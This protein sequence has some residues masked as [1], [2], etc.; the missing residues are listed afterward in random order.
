MAKNILIIEDIEPVKKVIERII[1]KY[2]LKTMWVTD[3]I[4][5]KEILKK[6]RF[7]IFLIDLHLD[8]KDGISLGAGIKK[9]FPNSYFIAMTG[10]DSKETFKKCRQAGFD[11][12]L[13][14]PF[15][16][17]EII[18]IMDNAIDSLD[19]WSKIED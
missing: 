6:N 15:D 4:Q 18:K 11:D 2:E 19:R 14:K 7:D 8:N 13:K 10:F 5:A 12:Y 3:V 9:I 17:K 1:S 16:H